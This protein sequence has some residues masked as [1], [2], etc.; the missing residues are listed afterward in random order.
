[1]AFPRQCD[2]TCPDRWV[3]PMTHRK[4]LHM[5]SQASV[6]ISAPMQGGR[7]RQKGGCFPC[8]GLCQ[9]PEE[10]CGFLTP[11]VPCLDGNNHK[12]APSPIHE[13]RVSS[14][15]VASGLDS[16]APSTSAA[17]GCGSPDPHSALRHI[18]C[19]WAPL[20]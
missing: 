20:K 11:S 4:T 16:T 17:P 14:L 15:L 12:S 18:N 5:L 1:M 7:V 10:V 13:L 6:S 3:Q 8:L 9:L 19:S 2:T